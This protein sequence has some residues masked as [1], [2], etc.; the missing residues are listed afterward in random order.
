MGKWWYCVAGVVA[1]LPSAAFGAVIASDSFESYAPGSQLNGQNGGTGFSNGYGVTASKT[2]N[3]TVVSKS[4]SYTGGA[5]SVDGGSNAVQVAGSADSNNLV[6]RAIPVQTGSPVYFGFLYNTNSTTEAFLQFGLENGST[7]EPHAS[8]GVQGIAG[9]GGGAEGFFA[10]V[11]N[12]GNT[13]YTSSGLSADT[14][15]YL[16]GRISKGAGSSTYNVVDLFLNPTSLDESSPTL[17]ATN[18]AGSGVSQFDNFVLRTARTDAGSLYDFDQL[19]IGT[20]FADVVPAP[21]P[22]ALGV[23]GVCAVAVGRRR[24]GFPIS[25]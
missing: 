7:A 17:T 9:N 8:V 6:T 3:V 24:R 15:Y 14:T 12:A 11:P 10:R 2:T 25:K 5:V 4:L 20:T 21:E 19:T 16:V 23:L 13:T 22:G 1:A 18:A